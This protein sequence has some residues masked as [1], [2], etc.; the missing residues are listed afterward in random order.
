MTPGSE[1]P[2]LHV[3][4]PGTR[5]PERVET[6]VLQNGNGQ[7]CPGNAPA[8][9]HTPENE[10]TI[11]GLTIAAQVTDDKGINTESGNP[12]GAFVANAQREIGGDPASIDVEQG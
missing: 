6:L 12:Y 3:Q 4:A 9:V 1:D 11:L 2:G 10:N 5:H 8:I 7:Q